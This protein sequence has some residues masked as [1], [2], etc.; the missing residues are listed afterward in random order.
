[1]KKLIAIFLILCFV[2]GVFAACEKAEGVTDAPT[3]A[4]TE[5][6]TELTTES[7][8]ETEGGK[9]VH[10][11]EPDDAM[12]GPLAAEPVL[13][14]DPDNM[15]EDF[16]FSLQFNVM[17][18]CSY[19]SAV[20]ELC[21]GTHEDEPERYTT[22]FHMSEEQLSEVYRM[23]A[24]MDISSYPDEYDPINDPESETKIGCD[25]E[26]I[27]VLTVRSG[28]AEKTV[29]AEPAYMDE[30]Y[31]DKSQAFLYVCR[32]IEDILYNSEEWKALP[33]NEKLFC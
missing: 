3:A 15:P 8:S 7:P 16:S 2:F 20:D 29:R 17:G 19:D 26:E 33:E 10:M 11:P 30:G 23:I 6:P 31:D 18:C 13:T 9:T 5:A 24:E 22:P 25:P 1:M 32:Y 27:L 21:G 14:L 28:G 12:G 4:S